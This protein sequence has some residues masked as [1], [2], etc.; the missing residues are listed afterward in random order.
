MLKSIVMMRIEDHQIKRNYL[1]VFPPFLWPSFMSQDQSDLQIISN[2]IVLIGVAVAVITIISNV[3][4]AK[5]IQTVLF[6]F[7]SRICKDYVKSL[8]ILKK[9]HKSG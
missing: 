8:H 2:I 3:K 6:L 5:K 1:P 9:V 7:K 4:T